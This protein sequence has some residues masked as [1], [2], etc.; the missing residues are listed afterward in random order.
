M[1][2]VTQTLDRQ[3]VVNLILAALQDVLASM[4]D[5]V[6][7]P[8]ENTRLI[9]RS[10]VL[11]S[12]GLVTLIVEVEQR[13]EADHDLVVVLADDRAMSQTRSPFLSVGTLADYVMQLAAE[14][15]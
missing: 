12:M 13:L 5:E 14:Q 15:G 9:G 4:A 1:E 8:D 10:A 7:T 6:V 3:V 2:T 11:D